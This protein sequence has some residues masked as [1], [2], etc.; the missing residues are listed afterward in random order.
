MKPPGAGR[1]GPECM[2][3]VLGEAEAQTWVVPLDDTG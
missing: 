3:E 1:D 2:W